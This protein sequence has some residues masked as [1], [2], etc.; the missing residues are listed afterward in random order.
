MSTD[1][2]ITY[3]IFTDGGAR[4]NPGPSA[5]AFV[6]YDRNNRIIFNK[7]YYL[8]VA[9][10]NFAEYDALLKSILWLDSQEIKPTS[11]IYYL[12]SLLIVNQINGIYKVKEPS[13][14]VIYNQIKSIINKST[15]KFSFQHIPRTKNQ[16]ADS[17]VNE[18][19]D[20]Q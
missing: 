6:V 15:I 4:G 16:I 8:G 2:N 20:S 17:L 14:I 9:T 19:L 12:D 13:L 18:T 1:T 10:N 11:V 7:G 3:Q 5:S